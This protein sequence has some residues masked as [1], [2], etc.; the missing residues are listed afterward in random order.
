MPSQDQ[1][2]RRAEAKTWKD[3]AQAAYKKQL[4][5][6]EK[7]APKDALSKVDNPSTTEKQR[8]RLTE[9]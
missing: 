1:I 8:S 9:R 5:P 7:G 4:A 3:L 2:R 6:H